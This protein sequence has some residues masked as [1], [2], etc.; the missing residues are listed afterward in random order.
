M[1]A[2]KKPFG[3]GEFGRQLATA[4]FEWL[5][6]HGPDSEVFQEHMAVMA[7]D[8]G[9]PGI[10]AEELHEQLK[11]SIGNW[12]VEEVKQAR[13]FDWASKFRHFS[14]F[15]A[16]LALVHQHWKVTQA[17]N[18]DLEPEANQQQDDETEAGKAKQ[19]ETLQGKKGAELVQALKALQKTRHTLEV[20]GEV[21][22]DQAIKK[23]AT[24][25]FFSQHPFAD[26]YRRVLKLLHEEGVPHAPNDWARKLQIQWANRA[27]TSELARIF[28]LCASQEA[29]EKLGFTQT[30]TD[31]EAVSQM[32]DAALFGRLLLRAASQRAWTMAQYSELAP[33]NWSGIL[34]IDKTSS[35]EAFARMKSDAEIVQAALEAWSSRNHCEHEGLGVV[36]QNLWMHRLALVQE[37]VFKFMAF[38]SLL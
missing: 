16:F 33:E 17:D 31:D 2:N 29:M 24:M 37:T 12:N 27:W 6:L 11:S 8:M 4:A 3:T 36:F 30:V 19:P 22:A 38:R 20:A 28:G 18:A 34:D 23:Y 13:F 5:T 7:H 26:E 15:W 9:N 21:L 35:Q 14:K 25:I 32:Q 10:S 1:S